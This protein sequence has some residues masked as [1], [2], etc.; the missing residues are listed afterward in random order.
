MCLVYAEVG[1]KSL[2]YFV[3]ELAVAQFSKYVDRLNT[4]TMSNV[5]DVNLSS[6][7]MQSIRLTN[8]HNRKTAVISLEVEI[9]LLALLPC[10]D[11]LKEVKKPRDFN[12]DPVITLFA[13]DFQAEEI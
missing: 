9:D 5:L 1:A 6:F 2:T 8:Y 13:V 3:N 11:C 7:I 12:D 4:C 10:S